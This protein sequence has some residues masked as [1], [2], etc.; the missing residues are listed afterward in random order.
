MSKIFI[1][2]KASQASN[3]AYVFR[4]TPTYLGNDSDS[5]VCSGLQ[6]FTLFH[7]KKTI[8]VDLNS[9][10]KLLPVLPSYVLSSGFPKHT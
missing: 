10:L 4:V 6:L 2:N 9:K 7:Y 8:I 1:E 3:I 5:I